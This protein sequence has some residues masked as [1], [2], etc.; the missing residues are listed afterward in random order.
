MQKKLVT[1]AV[2]GALAAPAA[3]LAQVE[4][5]GTIHMS[6]NYM[7]YG[8]SST[9]IASVSKLD[10]A[11]HASNIGVRARESLGGGL[12]AWAQVETNASMERSN[13]IAHTSNFASRNSAVGLQGGFGNVF[14]G[15]WTT[16][17]ADLDAL[18]G[19]GTVATYGPITSIIGRRE[20]TGAAP[21]PNC[22][23]NFSGNGGGGL[24]A[25]VAAAQPT[26]D[27]VEGAGGPGHP[28]W[29]RISNSVFY[30]SPVFGGAQVKLA[31]QTNQDK[32]V[33]TATTTAADPQ[34][35]SASVSWAGMG[36]RAR[37]GAA[38]DAHKEFSAVGQTDKG[39]RVTGG[40]NFGFVDVGLAYEQMEYKPVVLGVVAETEA[41]QWGIQ[42]AIPIGQGAIRAAYSVAEDLDIIGTE[43]DGTGAKQYNIGYDYRFS[44]RT[45]LGVG[46]AQIKNEN[47]AVFT[48]SGLSSSNG[49]QSVTPPPGSDVSIFFTSLIHRF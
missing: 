1:L 5:Y 28:F 26:C 3:A 13:N 9:G 11:S 48:W 31:Y 32:S 23:N 17:W 46:F 45:T 33:T 14:V 29:R 25:G 34:M 18:W 15:Q 8:E 21:N 2:A 22:A 43:V 30:Q 40:F 24:P 16:P 10:V 20:T 27:S 4:V 12:S 37:V 41:T 36:G 47:L 19:I 35:W 6:L 49:G 7:K 39:W 38:Y 42:L 44:K